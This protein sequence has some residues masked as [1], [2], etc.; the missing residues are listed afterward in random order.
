[1]HRFAALSLVLFATSTIACSDSGSDDGGEETGGTGG[2]ATGGSATG[3]SSGSS[4]GGSAMG[5]SSG[6]STGGSATGGNAT[7]G[8]GGS[9]TGG[10]ETG[11]TG[12]SGGGG[13]TKRGVCGQKGEGTV[14]Q[15]A[16]EAMESWYMVSQENVEEGLLDEYI[17]EIRFESERTGQAP[18]NCTD[19][20]GAAC[21]WTHKTRISNPTVVTNVDGACEKNELAWNAAWIAMQDGA[22]SSYG[23]IPEYEGHDS[24]LMK[25]SGT[26][27]AETWAVLGR[28]TW[29]DMTGEF[30]FDN[31]FGNCR[32]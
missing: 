28:A 26:A 24:V 2:S 31:R 6:A 18:P 3:G 29:D 8:S 25:A 14:T 13:F 11:G 10:S 4:T 16:Y 32:Y 21:A 5:G 9:G 15:T 17:C 19:L 7:G 23:F 22:E 20:D 27:G 30:T 12:G 1:M